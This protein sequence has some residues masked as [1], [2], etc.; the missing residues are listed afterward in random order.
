MSSSLI[1]SGII[2]LV[3]LD[4]NFNSPVG[5]T[6]SISAIELSTKKFTVRKLLNQMYFYKAC[7]YITTIFIN[8]DIT[9][10]LYKCSNFTAMG[11]IVIKS[12][13]TRVVT[14]TCRHSSGQLIPNGDKIGLTDRQNFTNLKLSNFYDNFKILTTYIK[15]H[16]NFDKA[17][18]I[19]LAYAEQEKIKLSEHVYFRAIRPILSDWVT[20]HSDMTESYGLNAH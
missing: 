5:F 8:A 15:I 1:C 11:I 19:F 9:V 3:S 10:Y 13:E 6:K 4:S 18:Q 7:N 16:S 14:Y 20:I 17:Y 12:K 2:F